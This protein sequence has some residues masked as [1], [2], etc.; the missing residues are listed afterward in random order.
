MTTLNG[1]FYSQNQNT[2]IVIAQ[3]DFFF[4][5]N[6][7]SNFNSR[8]KNTG[9][10]DFYSKV[11]KNEKESQYGLNTKEGLRVHS[12]HPY[13]RF[14]K[15][16]IPNALD[17]IP[18]TTQWIESKMEVDSID[19]NFP[20]V[21][22]IL[23]KTELNS[24]EN[25]ATELD[26]P[27]KND[28]IPQTEDQ[29]KQAANDWDQASQL[30]D[31]LNANQVKRKRNK[32]IIPYIKPMDSVTIDD[33]RFRFIDGRD[34]AVD[35]TLSIDD[36]YKFNALKTDYFE[37]LPLPNMGQGYNKLGYDF[38]SLNISPA[39][40]A[41]NKHYSYVE[42][43]DIPYFHVPSPL[44]DLFFKTTFE[45]GHHLDAQLAVNTSPKFNIYV[46]FKGFRSLGKYVSA[47]SAS[48][49]FR[50]STQYQNYSERFRLRVHYA[51]QLIENQVN[52]G[53]TTTSD[54]YY[55]NAPYY[56]Q[57]DENGRPVIDENGEVVLIKRDE[58]LDRSILETSI[59][60]NNNL[61]GK[62]TFIEPLFR[63]IPQ[64]KG[65]TKYLLELG[66][67][68]TQER[69]YYDFTLSKSSDYFGNRK[70]QSGSG[71]ITDRIDFDTAE[72]QVF[73]QLDFNHYG[74][75]KFN[76]HFRSWDYIF[77]DSRENNSPSN[78]NQTDEATQDQE[79]T[80]EMELKSMA[81]KGNQTHYH[82]DW[83]LDFQKN[84]LHAFYV[85]SLEPKFSTQHYG[86]EFSREL[87][88]GTNLKIRY[89]SL[90]RPLDFNYYLYTSSYEPYNWNNPDWENQEIGTF[91]INWNHP[92]WGYLDVSHSRLEYFGYFINEASINDKYN[93]LI[94][95]PHQSEELIDY[96]K[97]RFRHNLTL[98]KFSFVNMVQFQEVQLNY[99]EKE[100]PIEMSDK[101]INVPKWLIRSSLVF[102]SH[103]FNKQLWLNAGLS[104]R[105]FTDFYANQH[106]PLL[107]QFVVQNHTR[108]GEFPL[109]E[110]FMNLKVQQTRI[111]FTIENF[112]SWLEQNIIDDKKLY[113]FYSDPVT[114]YRDSIIR[115]GLIWNF[116][117]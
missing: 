90:S 111:F 18:E 15:D 112:A 23:P 57:G 14:S 47:R 10:V 105:F 101:I 89:Q 95:K 114:P 65:G 51:T 80:T 58:F 63:F 77:S 81:N 87:I 22:K 42:K 7:V 92:Q 3:P 39:M 49:Q 56:P 62:R 41:L 6:N 34:V 106:H 28:T 2:K 46:G 29:S 38:M 100:T 55:V 53:L 43:E 19:Q 113:D 71:E 50:M 64:Q 73:S 37:L 72:H 30:Q 8:A 83:Q 35:T 103:L 16:S 115:F 96:L 61:G 107:G 98:G 12:I 70:E 25:L 67:N 5:I 116:F 44:T 110:V 91:N 52:G 78:N 76:L 21:D 75:F 59:E 54:Y 27:S 88:W 117:Q 11:S 45:Q 48:S 17:S 20:S 26:Q 33:Y 24:I 69:K 60:G 9:L 84:H 102:S 85:N 36:H 66:Y 94:V 82:L 13:D 109:A 74:K 1:S 99:L 4:E 31:S 93:S 97:V 104:F 108:I 40:G 32:R 79:D 86:L 68:Y